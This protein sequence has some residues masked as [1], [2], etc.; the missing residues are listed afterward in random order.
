MEMERWRW[1]GRGSD[2]VGKRETRETYTDTVTARARFIDC[3]T[4]LPTLTH[5]I[6]AAQPHQTIHLPTRPY[7]C[8]G[9]VLQDSL[10]AEIRQFVPDAP[11]VAAHDEL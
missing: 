1:R 11:A 4:P 9:P 10:Q 6:V 5:T 8:C 7:P 2:R 3:T